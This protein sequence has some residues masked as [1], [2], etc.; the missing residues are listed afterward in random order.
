MAYVRL[1]VAMDKPEF[2]A[3]FNGKNHLENQ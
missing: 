1:D 2:M 3:G